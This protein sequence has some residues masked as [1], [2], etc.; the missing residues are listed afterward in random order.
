CHD[1]P[2]S[3]V[4]NPEPMSMLNIPGAKEV[5]I[6]LNSLSK[7][8]NMA[9]W[10]VGMVVGEAAYINAILRVK[11]NMDSGMFAPLQ[12]AAAEALQISRQWHMERNQ[13]Y[14]HRREIVREMIKV[15]NCQADP[16]QVGMF[17]WA[18]IPPHQKS[19]EAFSE[20][21]LNKCSVFITPG[22]IFGTAGD[23][24]IR[25]S[26]CTPAERLEEALGRLKAVFALIS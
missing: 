10:R 4:L 21:I 7:S 12:L 20:E 26:L 15:L 18:K 6:E 1:N 22:F 2:Y 16:D 9:G 25:I 17:M 11:S 13:V 24:Y 5:A 23:T 8:H 14:A 19:A 3:Y